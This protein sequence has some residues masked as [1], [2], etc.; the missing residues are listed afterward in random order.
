[1]YES[2]SALNEPAE[3]YSPSITAYNC[4]NLARMCLNVGGPYQSNS[5]GCQLNPPY[6]PPPSPPQTLQPLVGPHCVTG[7]TGQNR[8]WASVA[9]AR[10]HACLFACQLQFKQWGMQMCRVM[11]SGVYTYCTQPQS[12]SVPS[13]PVA[14]RGSLNWPVSTGDINTLFECSTLNVLFTY[15][16]TRFI[17]AQ[18]LEVHSRF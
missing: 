7:A 11:H 5:S 13:D 3:T 2:C 8:G 1:M 10:M 15:E 17:W 6:A 16:N 18:R 9:C 12:L 14:T 4:R